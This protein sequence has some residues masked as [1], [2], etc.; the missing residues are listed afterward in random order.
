MA[1]DLVPCP[2][3]GELAELPRAWKRDAS[4]TM[5]CASCGH[6][7]LALNAVRLQVYNR[8]KAAGL[9]AFEEPPSDLPIEPVQVFPQPD[10]KTEL[11]FRR[12]KKGG[13][14][15]YTRNVKKKPRG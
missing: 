8:L 4:L 10:G 7:H 9:S 6:V 2:Q 15:A 5:T 13:E 1:K 14:M 12:N 3:C 11:V